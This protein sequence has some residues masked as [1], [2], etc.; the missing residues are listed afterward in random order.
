MRKVNNY[1]KLFE[2]FEKEYLNVNFWNWFGDS[3]IVDDKGDPLIVYHGTTKDFSEFSDE[4]KGVRTKHKKEDVGYHFTNDPSYADAYAD[5]STM[6]N[7][8]TYVEMFPD[9]E[10]KV[11]H[12]IRNS[13]II[14]VYLRIEKPFYIPHA[15]IDEHVINQALSENCDGIIGSMG[16][17]IKEYVVFEPNQIKSAYGN[18]GD[19]G[20]SKKSIIEKKS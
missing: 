13:N 19:F 7:Y 10:E 11:K 3:K 14:P 15:K 5:T 2:E 4:M 16:D 12:N 6:A 18:N 9:E 17:W 1:I 8:L 20:N